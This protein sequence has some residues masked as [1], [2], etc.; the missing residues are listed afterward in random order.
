[1]PFF[2]KSDFKQ[3]KQ[4]LK[5]LTEN[6]TQ[7]LNIHGKNGVMNKKLVNE[8]SNYLRMRSYFPNG[9]FWHNF[10]SQSFKSDFKSMCDTLKQRKGK[11]NQ[12]TIKMNPDAQE[13]LNDKPRSDAIKNKLLADMKRPEFAN[14]GTA[15]QPM[16]I[17][18]E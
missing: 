4:L 13:F 6:D 15:K 8:V 16:K 7:A 10:S 9:I 1:M 5:H 18:S 3:F 11:D 14:K 17:M 12:S 2:V